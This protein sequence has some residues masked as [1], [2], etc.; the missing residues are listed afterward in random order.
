MDVN[1]STPRME[2]HPYGPLFDIPQRLPPVTAGYGA[3]QVSVA[4]KPKN[5]RTQQHSSTVARCIAPSAQS[6]SEPIKCTAAQALTTVHRLETPH[7]PT[8]HTGTF[9]QC[10]QSV[11][12]DMLKPLNLPLDWRLLVLCRCGSSRCPFAVQ[13]LHPR[14][15]QTVFPYAP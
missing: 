15:A 8:P 5:H 9:L 11:H 7:R 6:G 3:L 12:P 14:W 13:T 1:G 2:V 4:Q 10:T